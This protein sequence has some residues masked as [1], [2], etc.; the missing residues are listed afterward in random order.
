[1]LPYSK[2]N[3]QQVGICVV[4]HFDPVL[5]PLLKLHLRDDS[6]TTMAQRGISQLF[7]IFDS[8]YRHS[9]HER[10]NPVN[11]HDPLTL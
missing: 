6:V 4:V 3:K 8:C 2:E 9:H 5:K 10:I 11:L 1:M 7:D